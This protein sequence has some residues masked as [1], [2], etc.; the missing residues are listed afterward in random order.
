MVITFFKVTKKLLYSVFY[1]VDLS[2]GCPHYYIQV[3]NVL[4]ICST[5]NVGSLP[6]YLMAGLVE[7]ISPIPVRITTVTH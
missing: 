6:L 4:Q 2:E 1:H 7:S 5:N 3:K